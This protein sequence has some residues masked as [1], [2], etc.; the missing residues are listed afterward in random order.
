MKRIAITLLALTTIMALSKAA[1]AKQNYY[2][3]L[4]KQ[5]K[6]S[7]AQARS[8]GAPLS[9]RVSASKVTS[10]VSSNRSSSFGPWKAGYGEK[11]QAAGEDFSYTTDTSNDAR[12]VSPMPDMSGDYW[13]NE[14]T[15]KQRINDVVTKKKN[16]T[17]KTGVFEA[18]LKPKTVSSNR[19]KAASVFNKTGDLARGVLGIKTANAQTTPT[20][21]T[22]GKI[23]VPETKTG[24]GRALE[25]LQDPTGLLGKARRALGDYSGGA[26]FGIT[27]ALGIDKYLETPGGLVYNT[28]DTPAQYTDA[29]G[30]VQSLNPTNPDSVFYTDPR[31]PAPYASWDTFNR[32]QSQAE[33]NRTDTRL[34]RPSPIS[35]PTSNPFVP[36]YNGA[37]D[38][39]PSE[40]PELQNDR[41]PIQ[42]NPGTIRRPFGN[43]SPMSNGAFSNG[44]GYSGLEGASLG[45]DAQGEDNETNWLNKLLGINTAQASEMPQQ[46]NT[47]G[48]IL[49]DSILTPLG[50]KYWGS[51]RTNP[52]AQL[53]TQ[54]NAPINDTQAPEAPAPQPIQTGGY[55]GGY[56]GGG[57]G[58][59]G[60]S[61]NPAQAQY[62][63]AIKGYGRQAKDTEKA[64]KRALASMLAGIEA[65]Y[66]QAQTQGTTALEKQKRED[67]LRQSGLFN[68]A[69]QDPN[70]EQ[71]IQYDQRMNQDYAGQLTDLL[72]KLAQGKSKDI[73]AAKSD[74]EG[75]RS[76]ALDS[77]MSAKSSAQQNLAQLLYSIQNDQ[78]SRRGGSPAVP[79]STKPSHQDI[80]NYVNDAVAQGGTWQEI[81]DDAK[82]QGID[83]STGSY[84]DQLL[85]R[86]FRG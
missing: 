60:G 67:L 21:P 30:E 57:G 68:F 15:R 32:S 69:N 8:M 13:T 19:E 3:K 56:T 49:P 76:A 84:L 62:E 65:E 54:S 27:E 1:V 16:N 77:I 22:P 20:R 70:S 9:S 41:T 36:Q 38:S 83:T 37:T 72:A 46:V 23:V 17:V 39:Q 4:A 2:N 78:Q 31:Q 66:G 44:K 48:Q 47:M 14:N 80:F 25:V 63:A 10:K 71:R 45:M 75:K 55:T 40:Q 81:A 29:G 79:K 33:T 18:V 74:I 59:K 73:L 11:P 86:Q 50:Q 7:Q 35:V 42:N 28:G 61:V 5:G 53:Q 64:Y 43:G 12:G 85:N 51:Q 34:N 52:F 82:A 26:D 24:L 58:F 6:I